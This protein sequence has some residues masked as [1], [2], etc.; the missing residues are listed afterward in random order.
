MFNRAVELVL[1]L[2]GGYVNDPDDPGGE[3]RYGI[4]KRAY[5]ELD[6]KG[7]IKSQAITIYRQDYWEANHV[8]SLPRM[9]QMAYFD[10]CVNSGGRQAALLLQRTV[11]VTQDGIV[12][13]KTL[14]AANMYPGI[15]YQD[16]L[17][18]RAL[19][20]TRLKTFDKYG[21]GWLRRLFK[22]N[23]FTAKLGEVT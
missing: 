18:E 4:S 17:A 19:F 2:E 6:I 20:Y 12:G 15:L 22:V 8:G 13:R 14:T 5:P 7:L 1:G 3:T 10:C 21:R 11:G 16:F 9:L 23:S